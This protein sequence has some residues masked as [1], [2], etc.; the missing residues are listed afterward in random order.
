MFAKPTHA[1]MMVGVLTL[2]KV[3]DADAMELMRDGRVQ[4][5]IT[6]FQ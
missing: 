2:W 3:F 5:C 4:V 1:N 6:L